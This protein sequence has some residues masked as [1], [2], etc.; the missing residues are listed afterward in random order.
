MRNESLKS[1]HVREGLQWTHEL[2]AVCYRGSNRVL[3]LVIWWS[4][5]SGSLSFIS[6]SHDARGGHVAAIGKDA[7]AAQM[8]LP[9]K[10]S[11]IE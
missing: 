11:A 1:Y 3:G 9:S 8:P 7:S 2:H 6:Q 10:N 5:V 4:P